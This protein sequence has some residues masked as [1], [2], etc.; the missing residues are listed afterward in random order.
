MLV[1]LNTVVRNSLRVSQP[2]YSL[3]KLKP[4][5][6]GDQIRDSDVKNATDSIVAYADFCDL[7]D[8]GAAAD[9]AGCAA[10]HQRACGLID[11]GRC[12]WFSPTGLAGVG[13][14]LPKSVAAPRVAGAATD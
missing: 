8:S 5:H 7:R 6:M 13:F 3:K 10:S 4:L 11:S 12:S 2:S 9:V 14:A 1:D